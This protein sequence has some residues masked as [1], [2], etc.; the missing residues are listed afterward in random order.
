MVMRALTSFDIT[1]D[2]AL[3][4]RLQGWFDVLDSSTEPFSVL[5]P[6]IYGPASIRRLWAATN[7]YLTFKRFIRKRMNGGTTRPDALQELIDSNHTE[8]YMT[9]VRLSAL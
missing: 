6:W 9:R 5:F 4:S 1:D 7:L 3:L 8:E 2:L